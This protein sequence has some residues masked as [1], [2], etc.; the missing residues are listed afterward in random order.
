MPSETLWTG[1]E[2][3]DGGVTRLC[4][5]PAVRSDAIHCE[6]LRHSMYA[7]S[8]KVRGGHERWHQVK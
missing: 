8:A 5:Y 7:P 6:D 2:A 3:R 4:L 1:G